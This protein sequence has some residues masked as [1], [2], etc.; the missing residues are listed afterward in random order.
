MG[1]ELQHALGHDHVGEL[2]GLGLE[3]AQA[4]LVSRR[5]D[6]GHQT[7]AQA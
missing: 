3:D 7:P 4:Q 6:I 5:M 1:Q 2:S